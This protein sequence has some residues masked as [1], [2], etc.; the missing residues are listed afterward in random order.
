MLVRFGIA[1]LV[2]S[3]TFKASFLT[4][5]SL[6]ITSIVFCCLVHYVKDTI[7]VYFVYLVATTIQFSML[8]SINVV[9]IPACMAI[10]GQ[11][12]GAYVFNIAIFMQSVAVVFT[13]LLNNAIFY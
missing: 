4:L 6:N 10:F 3:Q 12:Q 5:Y 2:E 8:Q 11:R 9:V 7:L 13:L 1:Y